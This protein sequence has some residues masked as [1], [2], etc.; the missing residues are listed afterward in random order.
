VLATSKSVDNS[1][2]SGLPVGEVHTPFDPSIIGSDD[3]LEYRFIFVIIDIHFVNAKSCGLWLYPL[4]IAAKRAGRHDARRLGADQE[5]VRAIS[6]A[7][8][9][10][11]R[12]DAIFR[13]RSQPDIQTEW[14]GGSDPLGR[15][16]CA[17]SG[18]LGGSALGSSD[19]R[20]VDAAAT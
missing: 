3:F 9:T 15:L 20:A 13:S 2:S 10:D 5:T 19:E 18:A 14:S 17:R 16:P 11:T 6:D 12:V 4:I 8:D 7:R 1:R